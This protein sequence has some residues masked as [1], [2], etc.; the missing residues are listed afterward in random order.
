MVNKKIKIY[1]V[2]RSVYPTNRII[3]KRA[4]D[5]SGPVPLYN[6]SMC[7]EYLNVSISGHKLIKNI[8][9]EIK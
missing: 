9:E 1:R 6:Y 3:A 4:R 8:W 5:S 2:R 7:L